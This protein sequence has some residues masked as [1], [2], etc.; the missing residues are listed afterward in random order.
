MTIDFI[1]ESFLAFLKE[2][3]YRK[4]TLIYYK[5]ITNQFRRFCK[6]RNTDVY[7]TEIGK[8]FSED[9]L[10]LKTGE[11]NISKF[12]YRGRLFRVL[13]SFYKTGNFD[14]SFPIRRTLEPEDQNF[15]DDFL[16]FNEYVKLKYTNESTQRK[17]LYSAYYLFKYLSAKHQNNAD[18]IT[19][20]MLLDYINSLSPCQIRTELHGLKIFFEYKNRK[21]LKQA[22]YGLHPVRRERIV[23]M[24]T[25]DERNRLFLLIKEEKISARDSAFLLLGLHTGIRACDA[26]KLKLSDID[27]NAETFSFIQ[28]KTGNP[29]T[30]PLTADLGNIFAKYIQYERPKVKSDY[31]FLRTNAPFKPFKRAGDTYRFIK[32]A[33]EKAGIEKGDRILGMHMLRHNAA[34]TMVLNEIPLETISAILGHASPDS[35]GIYI[36]TDE[37]HM[38]DCV[39]P[40]IQ[41]KCTGE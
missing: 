38:K 14:L 24:L 31:L 41:C 36:T 23:P 13:D 34:S 10:G 16:K 40:L 33:F 12:H 8:H 5:R 25:K 3:G 28:S 29:V 15:R 20:Q 18:E 1:C 30:L 7:T 27:W 32:R 6:E 21:D 35:T 26:I 37:E 17:C 22:L 19:S 9:V 4:S 11:F 2:N 39:L